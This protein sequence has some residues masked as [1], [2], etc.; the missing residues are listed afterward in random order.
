MRRPIQFGITVVV[1]RAVS[2]SP[3]EPRTTLLTKYVPGL[4]VNA[5]L[6]VKPVLLKRSTVVSLSL[7]VIS[8]I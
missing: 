1:L 5:I 7:R 6:T 3:S 8:F 4:T 2:C